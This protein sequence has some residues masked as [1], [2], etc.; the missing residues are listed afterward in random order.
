M[1]V[2]MGMNLVLENRDDEFFKVQCV[3]NGNRFEAVISK[4]E[5]DF[6]LALNQL[7]ANMSDEQAEAIDILLDDYGEMKYQE[8]YDNGYEDGQPSEGD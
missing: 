4:E 5:Y 2:H 1:G 7:I 6:Q 3:K 8:G